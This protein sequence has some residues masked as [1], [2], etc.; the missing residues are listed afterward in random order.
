MHPGGRE[1]ALAESPS[2][3]QAPER[4]IDA[5]HVHA[6]LV[7]VRL[8]EEAEEEADELAVARLEYETGRREVG[9][10]DVRQGEL[11]AGP[12]HHS[13][14]TASTRSQSDGRT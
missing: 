7:R 4:R 12:P 10:E 8:G 1:E 14:M 11:V 2:E 9:E 6:G 3:A 5:D 13:S